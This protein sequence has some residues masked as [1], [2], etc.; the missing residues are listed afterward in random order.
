MSKA[1]SSKNDQQTLLQFGFKSD[2]KSKFKLNKPSQV[3]SVFQPKRIEPIKTIQHSPDLFPTQMDATQKPLDKLYEFA[4]DSIGSGSFSSFETPS[5]LHE[6][7][8]KHRSPFLELTPIQKKIEKQRN[9]QESTS[10]F[11]SA[12][13]ICN[14][15]A[16]ANGSE[17]L[18]QPQNLRRIK[19]ADIDFVCE[20]DNDFDCEL[21]DDFMQMVYDEVKGMENA[22][23]HLNKASNDITA[24]ILNYKL[25]SNRASSTVNQSIERDFDDCTEG[26]QENKHPPK[27]MDFWDEFDANE[28]TIDD[29]LDN[30]IRENNKKSTTKEPAKDVQRNVLASRNSV[31]PFQ[32]SKAA[33]P[34]KPA[35]IRRSDLYSRSQ[36]SSSSVQAT[37]GSTKEY[38]SEPLSKFRK[39]SPKRFAINDYA[40]TPKPQMQANVLPDNYIQRKRRFMELDPSIDQTEERTQK[41]SLKDLLADNERKKNEDDQSLKRLK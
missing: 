38:E 2:I 12:N 31:L 1:K 13:D 24:K 14:V 41:K 33:S 9:A 37:S 40:F 17:K 7:Q 22:K 3:E 28:I 25:N 4:N 10:G 6:T 34:Q 11:V 26:K 5:I 32:Q 29:Q 35:E 18:N 30:N 20:L 15:T 21:D 36:A 27:N 19:K 39:L 8:T 16:H 23:V